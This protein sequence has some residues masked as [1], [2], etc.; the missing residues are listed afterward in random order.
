MFNW[1]FRR[2]KKV[3]DAPEVASEGSVDTLILRIY[4][5]THNLD[6]TYHAMRKHGFSPSH[7]DVRNVVY[8]HGMNQHNRRTEV[9][10]DAQCQS[11]WNRL[12]KNKTFRPKALYTEGQSNDHIVRALL[13]RNMIIKVGPCTYKKAFPTGVD[14]GVID[15]VQ[16]QNVP[17]PSPIEMAPTISSFLRDNLQQV[18]VF[19]GLNKV[20]RN[21]LRIAADILTQKYPTTKAQ[22]RTLGLATRIVEEQLLVRMGTA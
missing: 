2:S 3:I 21:I 19:P 22:L 17:T 9:K 1:L 6:K 10:L 5:H 4:K 18:R 13:R 7:M 8:G 20:E 12:P 15:P 16:I 14:T 11:I